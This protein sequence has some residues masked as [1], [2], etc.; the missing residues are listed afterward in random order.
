MVSPADNTVNAIRNKVRHLTASPSESSLTTANLDGYINDFYL[1]DFPYGIKIDQM[2][3]VYAFYTQPNIDRYPLD[4]NYNVGVRM[5]VYVDGIEGTLYKDRK[6]F[7]NLWPMFPTLFNNVI[8]GNGEQTEYTFNLAAPFLSREVTIGGGYD[9]NGNAITA[10]DDG[11]G[12]IILQVPN[13]VLTVPP[14]YQPAVGTTQT[15]IPGMHNN[16]TANPG[17]NWVGDATNSFVN[18][19]GTVNYVTGAFSIEFPVP[20]ASGSNLNIW[21]AQYVPGRPYCVLFWNNEFTI[22]PVPKLAHKITVETYLT[23]V[24]FLETT[25]VPVVQQWW[26]YIALGAALLILEDR[27]D[28]EG[29]ENLSKLFD[30][31][32][33]LVLERQSNEEINMPNSTVFNSTYL[34]WLN[35]GFGQ[36]GSYF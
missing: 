19:I 18:A 15:P 12:N 17:L 36:G 1:N 34:N 13:P 23:P 22:R 27:Q 30:R 35:G 2:R 29:I 14:Y 28:M 21:V 20:P 24:Q 7:L 25:D 3:K 11:N 16:N 8:V 26:K 31:Q 5:P 9:I 6:Q 4:V 10:S 32:E 33:G